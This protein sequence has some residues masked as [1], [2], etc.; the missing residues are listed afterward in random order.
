MIASLYV[1][2]NFVMIYHTIIAFMKIPKIFRASIAHN[3][4]YFELRIIL[5]LV[6]TIKVVTLPKNVRNIFKSLLR[7]Y[8]IM[9]LCKRLYFESIMQNYI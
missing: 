1:T 4:L 9:K 5:K 7:F 6:L 3:F 2:I 8:C